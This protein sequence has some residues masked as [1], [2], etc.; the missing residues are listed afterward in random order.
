MLAGAVA[1]FGGD[2]DDYYHGTPVGFRAAPPREPPPPALADGAFASYA[3]PP[4][5]LAAPDQA[6]RAVDWAGCATELAARGAVHASDG[7]LLDPDDCA[8]FVEQVGF[9]RDAIQSVARIDSPA[10]R[11]A[12]RA[13]P[14]PI[15]RERRHVCSGTAMVQADRRCEV[16]DVATRG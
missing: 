15:Q 1:A 10:A 13:M 5:K 16:C 12:M 4:A 7:P 9:R 6:D 11:D 8:W 14:S 2:S 3:G